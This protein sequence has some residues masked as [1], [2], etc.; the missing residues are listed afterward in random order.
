MKPNP[1]F[2][3]AGAGEEQKN[4]INTETGTKAE[5]KRQA[6]FAGLIKGILSEI[7]FSNGAYF[8]DGDDFGQ[9]NGGGHIQRYNPGYLF[10]DKSHDLFKQ[11]DNKKP[12][13]TKY[14]SYD[15]KHESTSAKGKTTFTRLTD[16]WRNAQFQKDEK[17]DSMGKDKEKK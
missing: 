14:S 4:R 2:G 5:A 6:V 16:K 9:K 1:G 17:S 10:T 8:W 3:V 12:G 13:K 11:G 7:D 15:Y